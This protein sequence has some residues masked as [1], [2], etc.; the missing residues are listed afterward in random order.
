MIFCLCVN[1]IRQSQQLNNVLLLNDFTLGCLSHKQVIDL[2]FWLSS[3][4][5]RYPPYMLALTV[6]VVVV[7]HINN[8]NVIGQNLKLKP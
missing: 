8:N 6:T 5:I 2:T 1:Y 4:N 7:V 3:D